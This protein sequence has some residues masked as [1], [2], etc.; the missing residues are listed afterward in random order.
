MEWFLLVILICGLRVLLFYCC[1][2]QTKDCAKS[3]W[4]VF[5]LDMKWAMFHFLVLGIVTGIL[6]NL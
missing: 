1:M 4:F 2:F 5:Y 6:I 3:S